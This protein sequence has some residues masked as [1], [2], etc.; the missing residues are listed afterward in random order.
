MGRTRASRMARTRYTTLATQSVLRAQ[1]YS[2]GKAGSSSGMFLLHLSMLSLLPLLFDSAHGHSA[3]G[4]ARDTGMP[5]IKGKSREIHT[6][7]T[8]SDAGASPAA[9]AAPADENHQSPISNLR[10]MDPSQASSSSSS[11]SSGSIL[12]MSTYHPH[13]PTFSLSPHQSLAAT[14][15]LPPEEAHSI[16]ESDVPAVPS[17]CASS[18]EELRMSVKNTIQNLLRN[19][20]PSNTS[21]LSPETIYELPILQVC[22]LVHDMIAL[23]IRE[24][25]SPV[26]TIDQETITFLFCLADVSLPATAKSK[27]KEAGLLDP[28]WDLLDLLEAVNIV[29]VNGQLS[30]HRMIDLYYQILTEELFD[31]LETIWQYSLEEVSKR[32]T[33]TI[34][35]V[36]PAYLSTTTLELALH[37]AVQLEDPYK[38]M[39][40]WLLHN[41]LQN[42]ALNRD[43]IDHLLHYHMPAFNKFVWPILYESLSV[44]YLRDEQQVQDYAQAVNAYG[45]LVEYAIIHTPSKRYIYDVLMQTMMH[46]PVPPVL[47]Q[48]NPELVEV[49]KASIDRHEE[50]FKASHKFL[51]ETLQGVLGSSPAENETPQRGYTISFVNN[52]WTLQQAESN[53]PC[54]QPLAIKTVSRDIQSLTILLKYAYRHLR[55]LEIGE[56][57]YSTWI[58]RGLDKRRARLPE[59]Y[60]DLPAIYDEERVAY[61]SKGAEKYVKRH[62]IID[63]IR[64]REATLLRDNELVESVIEQSIERIASDAGM[65]EYTVPERPKKLNKAD[66][67]EFDEYLQKNKKHWQIDILLRCTDIENLLFTSVISYWTATSQT[68]LLRYLMHYFFQLIR[69]VQLAGLESSGAE[70]IR[71]TYVDFND[72][73]PLGIEM[74][75]GPA[76]ER[77]NKILC[78]PEILV[79]LLNAASK[80]GNMSLVE[81]CWLILCEQEDR[82]GSQ[83][84]KIPTAAYTIMLEAYASESAMERKRREAERKLLAESMPNNSSGKRGFSNPYSDAGSKAEHYYWRLRSSFLTAQ[85]THQK[86]IRRKRASHMRSRITHLQRTKH[87][88]IHQKACLEFASAI[89]HRFADRMTLKNTDAR[90]FNAALDVFGGHTPQAIQAKLDATAPKQ[91]IILEHSIE[92][93]AEQ[94]DSEPNGPSIEDSDIES[95]GSRYDSGFGSDEQK[96]DTRVKTS[97]IYQFIEVVLQ[98]IKAAG[99][100]LPAW[101]KTYNNIN[102]TGLIGSSKSRGYPTL[103][104]RMTSPLVQWTRMSRPD[105]SAST[106]PHLVKRNDRG[107]KRL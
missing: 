51:L 83:N 34:P 23:D 94:S 70:K 32:M 67:K 18:G 55:S 26:H 22:K 87:E 69:Q 36:T 35:D 21:A 8:A 101:T 40:S 45:I 4:Y 53:V 61:V 96:N 17:H 64:I 25:N 102:S 42:P 81:K 89:Y 27:L 58:V 107:R 57:L 100:R 31:I 80:M 60:V 6:S 9:A 2:R 59:E 75:I 92:T 93:S 56:L 74:D 46:V 98:D 24:G 91:D 33:S 48:V 73:P 15:P 3:Y 19:L 50:L 66:T 1:A 13:R 76:R 72:F 79:T 43:Q 104:S 28:H 44:T 54:G 68:H 78:T 38:A 103:P 12:R 52:A 14:P 11:N 90:F 86:R 97:P 49:A 5:D 16:S 29:D 84:W 82:W 65:P 63:S 62:Q 10:K 95:T 77:L 47:P 99:Y 106:R 41:T 30:G 71:F 105:H 88:V 7:A 37:I 39:L 85:V 20:V